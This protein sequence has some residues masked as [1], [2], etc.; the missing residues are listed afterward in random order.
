MGKNR[1]TKTITVQSEKYTSEQYESVQKNA[2]HQSTYRTAD[3]APAL[4]S[5]KEEIKRIETDKKNGRG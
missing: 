4:E 5:D 3:A 1:E 2:K